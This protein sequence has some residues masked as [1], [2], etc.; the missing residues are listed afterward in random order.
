VATLSFRFLGTCEG[1][2]RDGSA[3]R[4]ASRKSWA[5]LAYL[6][7]RAGRPATRESLAS[8][9]WSDR[10]R[11][12]ARSSLRQALYE[13]RTALGPADSAALLTTRQAAQLIV[14]DV[15]VLHFEQL[16]RS[17]NADQLQQAERLY[18]GA[19]LDGLQTGDPEFD[20]WLDADRARSCDLA[21][22]VL[23]SL[24][25]HHLAARGADAAITTAKRLVDLDPYY[26]A[27]HRLT[28]VALSAAGRRN[29]ALA[30]YDKLTRLLRDELNVSP[31]PE[32]TELRDSLRADNGS[33]PTQ[34]LRPP[35][36]PA[37]LTVA[38]FPFETLSSDP[39]EDR[40]AR[41]LTADLA[42]A[43]CKIP[44]LTVLADPADS[45]TKGESSELYAIK[46][47]LQ[48]TGDTVRITARLSDASGRQI[49]AGRFQRETKS[50]FALQDEIIRDIL[51]AFESNLTRG[52]IAR[53]ESRGTTNLK[54]WL[55]RVEAEG[56]LWKFTRASTNRARELY[57]AARDL[58]PLWP[59]PWG[60]L[61]WASWQDAKEGWSDS[62]EESIAEG[63]AF[64]ER[65]IELGPHEP[66]GYMQLGNLLTLR[67]EHE[68]AIE[69]REHA[70]QIA[71]SDFGA[72]C[73]LGLVLVFAGNPARALQVFRKAAEVAPR[74][75]A[76]LCALTALAHLVA[77]DNEAALIMAR[78]AIARRYENLG[79]YCAS[80]IALVALG[81]QD[82]AKQAVE[83]AQQLNPRYRVRDWVAS[84][85]G[86]KDRSLV[87]GFSELLARAGLP[88]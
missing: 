72:L 85:S 64:A 42:A 79:P 45:D 41:G 33:D 24:A 84:Q 82:E 69:L 30:H 74:Y 20:S 4:I 5:L 19:F 39:S 44:E 76:T 60:V 22:H 53:I 25:L 57:T 10:P 8:L 27:G 6:A 43:L 80:A 71:P 48:W 21:R 54:A 87:E 15:D 86:F 36:L 26:E 34:L 63:I 62:R 12:Q 50:F 32:T 81:R 7:V 3:V 58:D 38:V 47:T 75:P 88:P 59:V 56:E 49:W 23:E 83:A 65:S 11:D 1:R 16:A 68:R 9:L 51:V 37:R 66:I 40:F 17:G 31:T 52:D 2:L 46:G 55:L 14:E 29:E 67:G 13:L 77:G 35:A 28:M 78:R 18:R 70:V 73:G 61:A